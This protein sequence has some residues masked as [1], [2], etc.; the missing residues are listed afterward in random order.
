MDS[1]SEN[2]VVNIS[3]SDLEKLNLIRSLPAEFFTLLTKFT[4]GVNSKPS[5]SL[6]KLQSEYLTFLYDSGFSERH[7]ASSKY[8]LRRL[9]EYFKP[10]R[11][12]KDITFKEAIDFINIL[13]KTA[14]KGVRV[15][16]RYLKSI[17]NRFMCWGYI[18]VNPFAKIKITHSEQETEKQTLNIDELN[19]ILPYIS[20]KV[21]R[22]ICLAAF[23]SGLRR[24]ELVSL[25]ITDIN[26]SRREIIVGKSFKTKS[27]RI[28]KVPMCDAL[29]AIVKKNYPTET[30][31]NL[32]D[33]SYLFRG[34]HG[35]CFQGNTITKAFAGAVKKSGLDKNVNFHS[36]RHSL[37]SNL[38]QRGV[39]LYVIK[40]LLGHQDIKTTQIY[41]HLNFSDLREAVG[42]LNN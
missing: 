29:Y 4:N 18:E 42:C 16:L 41:S 28:R 6:I 8:V 17:F 14:S 12:V 13:R 19:T 5:P 11:E 15:Y 32:T 24:S 31:N 7:I 40:E 37:A 10:T 1:Q 39:S 36:L 3:P 34:K 27:R 21:I 35:R 38:V 26:L 20:N 2:I 9:I 30:V 25:M 22:D 33:S 23:Y